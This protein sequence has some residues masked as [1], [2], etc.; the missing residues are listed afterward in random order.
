[1]AHQ[2]PNRYLTG[3]LDWPNSSHAKV[4]RSI[5][6]FACPSHSARAIRLTQEC[7]KPNFRH[8]MEWS[9]FPNHQLSY[10][11]TPFPVETTPIQTP[12]H[13]I[14]FMAANQGH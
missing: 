11:S 4:S 5:R 13:C 6:H 1:M 14:D 7:S 12:T 8:H 3:R 9:S 2:L 10:T